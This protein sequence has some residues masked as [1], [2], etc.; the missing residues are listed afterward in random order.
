M[1]DS[2]MTVDSGNP[3]IPT[4]SGGRLLFIKYQ[5]EVQDK[6]KAIIFLHHAVKW[7]L[8]SLQLIQQNNLKMFQ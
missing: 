6:Y 8:N 2:F 7:S 1:F 4:G 5:D 3:D